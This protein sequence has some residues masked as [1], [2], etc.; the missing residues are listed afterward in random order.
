MFTLTYTL[1][2]DLVSK[3]TKWH[4]YLVSPTF[5]PTET[6]CLVLVVSADYYGLFQADVFGSD[7][8]VINTTGDVYVSYTSGKRLVLEVSSSEETGYR[9]YLSGYTT[10]YYLQNYQARVVVHSVN[11]TEGS[12]QPQGTNYSVKQSTS[13]LNKI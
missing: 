2:G 4:R 3:A 5:D 6:T 11:Q 9:L 13:F 10:S 7:G 1:D 8:K 12:C